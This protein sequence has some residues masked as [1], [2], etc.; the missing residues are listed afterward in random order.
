MTTPSADPDQPSPIARAAADR[1][2]VI[3]AAAEQEAAT[4]V[5]DGEARAAAALEAVRRR[6]EATERELRAREERLR[7]DR[8]ELREALD[9]VTRAL[10]KLA[11]HGERLERVRRSLPDDGPDGEGTVDVDL[12]SGID[13][14]PAPGVPRDRV[15]DRS[16]GAARAAPDEGAGATRDERTR[17]APDDPRRATP[18]ERT[19]DRPHISWTTAHPD[20]RGDVAAPTPDGRPIEAATPTRHGRPTDVG[21]AR[22]VALGMAADGRPRAEVAEHLRVELGL[23]DPRRVLDY[24]FGTAGGA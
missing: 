22:V 10:G 7:S 11:V 21:E 20:E 15:R 17:A 2:A 16:G 3:V 18:D 4:I 9:R 6:A 5:R 1:V 13:V 8:A 24:V 23:S 19:Q 12:T 14:D